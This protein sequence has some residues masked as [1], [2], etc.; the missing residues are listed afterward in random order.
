VE[1]NVQMTQNEVILKTLKFDIFRD[2]FFL[3]CNS[4]A[5]RWSVN[6]D[7]ENHSQKYSANSKVR[8]SCKTNSITILEFFLFLNL[9]NFFIWLKLA[10]NLGQ[11]WQIHA[12]MCFKIPFH[13][14]SSSHVFKTVIGS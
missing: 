3:F 2:F 5:R 14:T 8:S 1:K 11:L 7:D 9:L 6:P 12:Y 10:Y 4:L 13:K